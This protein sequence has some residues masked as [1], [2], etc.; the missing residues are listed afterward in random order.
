VAEFNGLRVNPVEEQT[1]FRNA[2][3]RVLTCI[4]AETGDTLLDIAE[5]IGVSLGTVSNA[6]NKK[7]DLC[8]TFINRIGKYYGGHALDP[9]H[10]LYGGRFV[11][12]EADESDDALPTT[13][14]AI[15]KLAVAKSPNSPGGERITHTEL[16]AME[17]D[18]DAAI[19]S[20]THLKLKCS[21]V[22][23]AA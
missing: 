17:M 5:R 8:R 3:A 16:L 10:A 20:L 14:A 18:I 4:Q 1:A 9:I 11:P 2:V 15:Y 6:A 22:R 19:R 12:L 13:T 23:S 21:L 7:N